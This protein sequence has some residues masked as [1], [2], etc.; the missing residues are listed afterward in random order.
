LSFYV[1]NIRGIIE[2]A[3]HFYPMHSLM[4]FFTNSPYLIVFSFFIIHFEFNLK[5][6]ITTLDEGYKCAKR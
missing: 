1:H 5:V 2:C 4:V 3:L 6:L